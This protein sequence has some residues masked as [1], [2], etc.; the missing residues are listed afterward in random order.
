MN[1]AHETSIR[2]IRAIRKDVLGVTQKQLADI[3][4]VSQTSVSRWED[5]TL[6]PNA[7]EMSRI[8]DFARDNGKP[9]SDTWFFEPPRRETPQ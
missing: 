6:S 3:A 5:G 2:P 4:G 8:R 1:Q 9:W 7:S